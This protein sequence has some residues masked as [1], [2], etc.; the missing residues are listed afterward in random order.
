MVLTGTEMFVIPFLVDRICYDDACHLKKYCMNPKRK[1]ITKVTERLANMNMVI[2][3]MHF[4]NHVD[5]WCKANCN[6]YDRRDLDGV[7]EIFLQFIQR[8]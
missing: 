3:K 7:S 2:D 6:P 5:K 1:S 8:C 4:R